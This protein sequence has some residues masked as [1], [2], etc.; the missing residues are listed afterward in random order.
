MGGLVFAA[1]AAGGGGMPLWQ[2]IVTTL[3][4]LLA[5]GGGIAALVT[6]ARKRVRVRTSLGFQDS[7]YYRS[8]TGEEAL[9]IVTDASAWPPPAG[10]MDAPPLRPRLLLDV[11]NESDNALTVDAV[12]V[13]FDALDAVEEARQSAIIVE[14]EPDATAETLAA[15]ADGLGLELLG[16]LAAMARYRVPTDADVP[17]LIERLRAERGVRDAFEDA[18]GHA[19]SEIVRTE[20]VDLN[21]DPGRRAY[22]HRIAHT[23]AA[24]DALTVP[25]DLGATVSLRG[26]GTVTLVFAGT[27][28]RRVADL[29][30]ELRLP[31][32]VQT[33]AKAA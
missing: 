27:K 29:S 11:R 22:S 28:R 21:L 26:S 4:A 24:H 16:Q 3:V 20:P 2:Y 5:A 9:R 13:A 19:H 6:L 1:E 31:A 17:G 8:T 15:T 12:E 23:L 32:Y 10:V 33:L 25:I 18:T 14:L 30:V 7:D